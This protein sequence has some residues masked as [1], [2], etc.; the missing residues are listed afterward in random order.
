[1]VIAHFAFGLG[2][3]L[4]QYAAA[5]ALADLHQTM[6]KADL[7][8]YSRSHPEATPRRFELGKTCAD[9]IVASR[10]DALRTKLAL[11]IARA[12]PEARSSV[13]LQRASTGLAVF[14][15]PR[16]EYTDDLLR[17]PPNTVLVGFWQSER[18]FR[19]IRN[20]LIR[21][22][23]PRRPLTGRALEMA[24][25]IAGSSNAVGVQVRRGDYVS[26]PSAASVHGACPPQYYR[27]AAKTILAGLR[28][29]RFFVFS[30]EPDWCRR[31]LDLPGRIEVVSDQG[32][33]DPVVDL[34]LMARCR[35]HIISN[36]T[37][38]WW[39]A[40]LAQASDRTVICPARWFRDDSIDTRDLL[41]VFWT[42]L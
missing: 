41:P 28:D 11:R 7:S 40:W 27:A 15:E 30:D 26:N 37:F 42:P 39:G 2:N 34:A 13:R 16:F 19:R 21:E 38:G 20:T 31:H 23:V 22:I 17:Q 29:P 14:L 25:R 6:V 9:F 35:H 3:Q 24:E 32:V 12:I 1:M 4:F 18:Y 36:S 5:K 10:F 8:W 33:D